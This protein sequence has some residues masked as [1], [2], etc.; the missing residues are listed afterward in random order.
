MTME[1]LAES[2][3]KLTFFNVSTGERI[4]A[5]FNP[6]EFQFQL[7][8]NYSDLTVPGAGYMP[9]QYSHTSNG[10]IPISLFYNCFTD[11]EKQQRDAAERFLLALCF[12]RRGAGSVPQHPPPR[13]QIVWPRYA[14]LVC[15]V[16]SLGI[17]VSRFNI[18]GE[19]V[20]ET[21]T[22]TIQTAQDGQ[23]F[24]ED[25]A[26]QGLRRPSSRPVGGSGLPP[27]DLRGLPPDLQGNR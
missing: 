20:E 16:R 18:L 2:P 10:T 5:Q 14:R 4:D 15:T 25:V 6:K 26:R 21:F 7:Q 3:P 9:E 11:E 23:L 12:P 27:L 13:C 8:V 24:S 19:P 1:A 17:Q 22:V